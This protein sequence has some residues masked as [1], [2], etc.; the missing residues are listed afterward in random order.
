MPAEWEPQQA[1]WFSWPHNRETWP[2]AFGG[3]EAELARALRPLA[4]TQVV[5]VNVLSAEHE[6]AVRSVLTDAG[7]WIGGDDDATG[8][9][10]HRIPT[11][12]AW[13]R[14]HG[15]IFVYDESQG[16]ASGAGE[17]RLTALDFGYNAWGGKYP[18]YDLDDAVPPQM[19]QALGVP[20]VGGGMILEG[21]SIDVS[22][23]GLLLT[24]TTCLLSRTRNPDL[25]REDI[26]ARL[27]K[28]LGARRTLWLEGGDLAGDDTD[29]HI[30]NLARFVAP[31]TV[32]CAYEPD[33]ASPNHAPTRDNL[34]RLRSFAGEDGQPL[35][36][37][38]PLPLPAPVYHTAADGQRHRLPASYANFLV[39]NRVVLVPTYDDPADAEALRILRECFPGREVVGAGSRRITWGL[40]SFHCLSQQVP[41]G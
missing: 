23:D 12:D 40:G 21:G 35:L 9:R 34:E 11:N 1:V 33:T 17:R 20:C 3:V 25:S 41:V 4:A 14:D 5:R 24:T 28:L 39:A 19:A 32:V 7:V 38:I 6:A 36:R 8:V 27:A 31:R 29:G 30:D 26:E 37:V 22:G 10:F 15:A 2:G 13:C 18:P 16:Q